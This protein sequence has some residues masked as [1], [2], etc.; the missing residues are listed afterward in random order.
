MAFRRDQENVNAN[1]LL[2]R[3]EEGA[4][5]ADGFLAE[6]DKT[7][8]AACFSLVFGPHFLPISIAFTTYVRVIKYLLP[9]TR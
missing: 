8:D 1:V 4:H 7:E 6:C 3:A 5:E 2:R 9:G